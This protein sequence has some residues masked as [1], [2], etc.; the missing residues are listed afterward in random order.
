MRSS[1]TS[2]WRHPKTTQELRLNEDPDHKKFTRGKRRNLPTVYDD[3]QVCSRDKSWKHKRKT[4]YHQEDTSDWGWHEFHCDYGDE[5]Y[6]I[7]RDLWDKINAGGYWYKHL[8]WLGIR[9]YGPD[10]LK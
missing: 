7:Y 3:L 9:W 1:Y 5:S 2:G 4:Q 8:R 10:L 6:M